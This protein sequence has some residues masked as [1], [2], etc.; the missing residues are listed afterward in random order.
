METFSQKISIFVNGNFRNLSLLFIIFIYFQIVR[1]CYFQASENLHWITSDWLINYHDGGL[2]R[3]GLAGSIFILIHQITGYEIRKIIFFTQTLLYA[4][5]FIS[6][7][8]L[9]PQ[10]L[11]FLLFIFILSP[12]TF[13]VNLNLSGYAG[14]KEIL[15]FIIYSLYLLH[16]VKLKRNVY[17]DILFMCCLVFINLIH[18]LTLFFIPFFFIAYYLKYK[19]LSLSRCLFYVLPL[20]SCNLILYLF[21]VKINNG[22]S[23]KILKENGLDIISPG[24]LGWEGGWNAIT[25]IAENNKFY[26]S[27]YIIPIAIGFLFLNLYKKLLP[28][29]TKTYN[30][31][32]TC[33]IAVIPLFI[34]GG[35]WGRW[36]NIYFI[37]VLLTLT[38][39]SSDLTEKIPNYTIFFFPFSLI[40]CYKVF[41]LGFSFY[42]NINFLLKDI[43]N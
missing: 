16:L 8:K 33:F 25:Y 26:L 3:R 42:T 6:L 7:I 10:K 43:F 11:N 30:L 24:M 38:T 23:F 15:I 14:R 32:I 19:K 22:T 31:F 36:I 4:L 27:L 18:E 9:L 34:L 28:F 2:K 37:L 13:G 17:Y 20:I 1:F 12:L 41:G 29:S 21:G 40:W 35:D 5:F 39:F